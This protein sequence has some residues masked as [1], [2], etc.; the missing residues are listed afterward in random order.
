MNNLKYLIVIWALSII[1]KCDAQDFLLQGWYW[2]YPKTTSGALW[3]DTIRLKADTLK[4]AGFTYVWLPPFYRAS[5]GSFSNGYD[6]KDLYDL[7]NNTLGPTGFGRRS[8]LNNL[9]TAFN[10]VG[11]KTVSDMIYNQRDG[12]LPENNPALKTYMAN[13]NSSKSPFPYDRMRCVLPLGGSSGNTAGDYYFKLSS[14]SGNG[15]FGGYQYGLYFWTNRKGFQGLSDTNE[16]SSHGGSDCGQPTF[17][18]QIGRNILAVVNSTTSDG[19]CLT[20]EYHLHI[21]ADDF[22]AT[23]DFLYINFSKRNSDYSDERI[24]GIWSGPRSQDI[25]GDLLY[26][27]NTDF[28]HVTSGLGFMNFEN[29][30]PNSTNAATTYLGGDWD[31][32]W[33]NYDYDQNI[34]DTENKLIDWTKWQ[35]NTVGIRGFRIDAVKHFSYQFTADVLNS[36]HASGYDPGLVVGE[37]YDSNPWTLKYWIDQ[38]NAGLNSSTKAAIFPRLFDFSLRWALKDAC[39]TYGYD[40]RNLFNASMV[41]AAGVSPFNVVTFVSNHDMRTSDQYINNDPILA[42]AYILT[43]NQIGIPTVFYPDYYYVPGFPNTGM[44][45]KINKLMQVHKD[46]IYGA[47]GRDYLTRFSSPYYENF[48]N[49]NYLWTTTLVFQTL[50]TTSGCDVITAINYAGVPLD[51]TVGINMSNSSLHD[52]VTF[53]DKIGNSLDSYATLSGGKL[54]LRLPA[55]SYSVWV[56]DKQPLVLNLTALIEGFYNGSIMTSDSVTVELHNV[57]SPYSIVESQK[58]VLN[59]GG[60]GTFSFTNAVNGIPYYIVI[61]HR[62]TI[63]TWSGSGNIFSNGILNYN[64]T[65]AATQA[66]GSNMLLKDGKY[67]LYSGD[68][69]Q[70]GGIDLSDLIGT[71]NDNLN[72]TPGFFSNLPSDVNGDGGVDLTDLIIVSNNNIRGVGVSFPLESAV[73][74]YNNSDLRK[75]N[76]STEYFFK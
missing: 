67:C 68:I 27:T 36:M 9:V 66:Y 52:G 33:F 46:Y 26:Q 56:Q 1:T 69:N 3:A 35:W 32:L 47:T 6:P 65:I 19:G 13:M 44:I 54:Q 53:S 39:D 40:V 59:T 45:N 76:F 29:F 51:V 7:G 60:V 34:P 48:N 14:A 43:N 15:R 37:F 22:N 4:K 74:H 11:L 20:D 55:R 2:D 70:D 25:I 28:T 75:D 21:N 57:F 64:F 24:Y 62:N 10:N 17:D 41:D 8:D 71:V 12:G 23:G 38:V 16:T 73:I 31:W 18:I 49:G 42:Y 5:S 61:K 58:G 30:K 72:G 63:E 50:Q